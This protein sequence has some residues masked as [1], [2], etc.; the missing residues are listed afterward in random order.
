MRCGAVTGRAVPECVYSHQEQL[1]VDEDGR[2]LILT[3]MADPSADSVE[4]RDICD[5]EL[6]LR[7][8]QLHIPR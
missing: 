8:D 5:G 3:G 2:P 1:A 4:S 6:A 7:C